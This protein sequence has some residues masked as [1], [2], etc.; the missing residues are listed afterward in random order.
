MEIKIDA[1]QIDELAREALLK[2]AFGQTIQDVVSKTLSNSY[3]NPIDEAL[4]KY[5]ATVA[6]NI[7]ETTYKDMIRETLAAAIAKRLT[8][9][10]VEQFTAATFSRIDRAIRDM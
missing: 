2:S 8:T 3:N 6:L 9:E 5:V 7:I 10:L 1:A 4:K